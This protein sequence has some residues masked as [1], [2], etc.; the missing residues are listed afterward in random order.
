MAK[1]TLQIAYEKL[2]IENLELKER[3]KE[4]EAALEKHRWIPVT[5]R[6]PKLNKVGREGA[7][8]SHWVHITDGE[9]IIDAY[10]YDYT[11]R[12]TK[13]NYATGK[14]WCCSGMKKSDITHWKPMIL[15][16]KTRKAVND[17]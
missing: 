1:G 4:L 7:T 15:P 16:E 9:K 2:V 11:K 10:Y 5:E 13:P 3:I 17:G 12:I 8:Q 6:L 14:G